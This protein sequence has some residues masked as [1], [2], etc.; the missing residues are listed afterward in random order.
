MPREAAYA[1]AIGASANIMFVVGATATL[2]AFAL[3]YRP[4]H[5]SSQQKPFVGMS[6]V[7]GL[8]RD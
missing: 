7:A 2:L 4:T 3:A 1:L 6:F 8:V 5:V